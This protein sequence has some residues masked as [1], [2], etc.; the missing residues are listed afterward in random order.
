MLSLLFNLLFS[1]LKLLS[2]SQKGNFSHLL[3][4]LD[5]SLS[6][7]ALLSRRSLSF[8]LYSCLEFASFE[9]ALFH[10]HFPSLNLLGLL[11]QYSLCL[12]LELFL[13]DSSLFLSLLGLSLPQ[14]FDFLLLCE[15]L[16]LFLK[17]LFS[18]LLLLI[19]FLF[20]LLSLSLFLLSFSLFLHLVLNLQLLP[21]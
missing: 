7:K 13:L 15:L 10:F 18:S 20:C 14:N 12:R 11:L 17:D 19:E 1:L 9:I 3:G 16:L 4:L 21:S 6:L 2:L 8:K 5:F